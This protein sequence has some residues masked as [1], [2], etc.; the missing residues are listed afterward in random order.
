MMS[1]DLS[2]ITFF[3]LNCPGHLDGRASASYCFC[4]GSAARQELISSTGRAAKAQQV[5]I[6][7]KVGEAPEAKQR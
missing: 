6:R 4:I 5:C 1:L 3:G 2:S 7:M